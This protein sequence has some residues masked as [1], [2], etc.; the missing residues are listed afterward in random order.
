[1]INGNQNKEIDAAELTASIIQKR[2]RWSQLL[3][4]L[5]LTM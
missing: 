3:R 4:R 1:M 2:K 5:E